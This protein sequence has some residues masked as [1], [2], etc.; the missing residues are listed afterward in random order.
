MRPMGDAP[1]PN[2]TEATS[3]TTPESGAE[4]PADSGSPS[5]AAGLGDFA[6]GSDLIGLP[7][8]ARIHAGERVLSWDLASRRPAELVRPA[9]RPGCHASG[10]PLDGP[11]FPPCGCR[12]ISR[13]TLRGDVPDTLDG[14]QGL[15]PQPRRAS[16]SALPAQP[17]RVPLR[18][19]DH[20]A[21]VGLGTDRT[22]RRWSVRTAASVAL[23]QAR[24]RLSGMAN[25]LPLPARLV[26]WLRTQEVR[27][28]VRGGE[29]QVRLAGREGA[30]AQG[31]RDLLS[32]DP[33][34]WTPEKW[35]AR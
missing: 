29:L 5:D 9:H 23:F 4:A 35:G 28:D 21:R 32:F 34:D 33:A 1:I 25:G 8:W 15:Q 19:A 20:S 10:L 18:V 6:A 3:C 11:G 31:P 27:D 12:P 17:E 7:V 2:A 22:Q 30:V 26:R 16:V 24:F 13:P 14:R